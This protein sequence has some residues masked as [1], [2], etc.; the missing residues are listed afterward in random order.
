MGQIS[1]KIYAGPG[2]LLSGNRQFAELRELE[3]L[4]FALRLASLRWRGQKASYNFK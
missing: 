3:A 2:S 1:V 4:S